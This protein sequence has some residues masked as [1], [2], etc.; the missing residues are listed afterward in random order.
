MENISILVLGL[1][2]V[3]GWLTHIEKY[4]G[5]ETADQCEKYDEALMEGEISAR[6]FY[7]E[8]ETHKVRKS[9]E[10]WKEEMQDFAEECRL[11]RRK[12]R[13]ETLSKAIEV[14]SNEMQVRG[15]IQKKKELLT[16]V[17]KMQ[18]SLTTDITPEKIEKAREYPIGRIIKINRNLALCVNHE[19][20]H[21][22]MN[23]KNNFA[24]CHSCGY[25][26]DAIGLYMKVNQANFQEAVNALQ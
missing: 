2:H 1:R 3:G 20:H 22:S 26:A 23:C 9:I 12:E 17:K 16:N 15:N 4:L 21:P 13:E 18:Q 24:F 8:T 19:D 11:R 14:L 6:K 25:T 10:E 5:K 7:Y